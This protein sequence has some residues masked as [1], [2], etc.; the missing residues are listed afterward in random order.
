MFIYFLLSFFLISINLA[1]DLAVAKELMLKDLRPRGPYLMQNNRKLDNL[2]PSDDVIPA[3]L[4]NQSVYK[5]M[6]QEDDAGL[7]VE[8]RRQIQTWD[9][10]RESGHYWGLERFPQFQVPEKEE[11]KKY[12]GSQTLKYIDK[13]I[14]GEIKRAD[15]GS[16]WEKVGT[17]EK[18]LKP[19]ATVEV[20]PLVKLR[21]KAKVLEGEGN[22][23]V[24]NPYMECSSKIHRTGAVSLHLGKK[25]ETLDLQINNDFKVDQNSYVTSFS[26]PIYGP[27][28]GKLSSAQSTTSAPF[29]AQSEM[30]YT[31]NYSLEI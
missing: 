9:N 6:V 24:E 7:L 3:T 12:L 14:S 23:L 8:V 22:I 2:I 17:I 4:K 25:V 28:S 26:R 5:N 1:F 27:L 11:Q 13:R 29:N 19:A 15:K 31:L 16:T 30:I 10:I 20:S 18:A 21:F